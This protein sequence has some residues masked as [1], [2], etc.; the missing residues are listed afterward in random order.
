MSENARRRKQRLRA[1]GISK[2]YCA[3]YQLRRFGGWQV[4]EPWPKHHSLTLQGWRKWYSGCVSSLQV[5]PSPVRRMGE[6]GRRPG[7]GS[8]L[9]RRRKF[10]RAL[11]RPVG[12]LLPLLRNGRRGSGGE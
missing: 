1:S 8:S 7:E 3:A 4:L 11:I 6:G 12:H 5:F 10:R 9:D 2:Q